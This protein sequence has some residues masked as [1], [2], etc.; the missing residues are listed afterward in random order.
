MT[1]TKSK[2]E[3]IPLGG[4]SRSVGAKYCENVTMDSVHTIAMAPDRENPSCSRTILSTSPFSRS[5][6]LQHP[7]TQSITT[8]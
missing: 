8:Q 1:A 3:A 5:P 2:V 7:S 6:K 4:V